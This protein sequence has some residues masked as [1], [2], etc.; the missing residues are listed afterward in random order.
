MSIPLVLAMDEKFAVLVAAGLGVFFL[1]Y[2]VYSIRR[3]K[4]TR[5]V[6]QTKREVAAYVAEGSITPDDAVKLLQAGKEASAESVSAIAD[7]VAWGIISPGKAERLI[8]A[9]REEKARAQAS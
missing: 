4:E 8:R 9:M 3:V 6:E 7:G 1:V 5:E 2:V